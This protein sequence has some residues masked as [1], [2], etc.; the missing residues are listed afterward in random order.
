MKIEFQLKTIKFD[1][2][3][4]FIAAFIALQTIGAIF[5]MPGGTFVEYVILN[6]FIFVVFPLHE[7][8]HALGL[9]WFCSVPENDIDF[10]FDKDRRSWFYRVKDDQK[11]YPRNGYIAA[12]LLPQ[13]LVVIFIALSFLSWNNIWF[14]AAAVSFAIG[15]RDWSVALSLLKRSSHAN[16][17]KENEDG[18]GVEIEILS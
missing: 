18:I 1:A 3:F 5:G 12:Q 10:G 9:R 2:F 6:I 4:L 14:I 11:K 13:I 7:L 8:F 15:S 16:K 17:I